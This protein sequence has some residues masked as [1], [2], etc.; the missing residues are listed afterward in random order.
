MDQVEIDVVDTEILQR[1]IKTLSN[2]L[3]EGSRNLARDLPN[4]SRQR[5][6]TE[7]SVTPIHLQRSRTA[8]RRTHVYLLQRIPRCGTA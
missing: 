1:R 2:A 6:K 7:I 5:P 3:V 8:V 4:E